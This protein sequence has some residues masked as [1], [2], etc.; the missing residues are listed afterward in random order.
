M[1][2]YCN[3]N[4]NNVPMKVNGKRFALVLRNAVQST[5][6]REWCAN[7]AQNRRVLMALDIKLGIKDIVGN[8]IQ[9]IEANIRRVSTYSARFDIRSVPGTVQLTVSECSCSS[10]ATAVTS[11]ASPNPL[12]ETVIRS[13]NF[14]N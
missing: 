6:R 8:T 11:L 5:R 14:A 9:Q 10:S 12:A 13:I 4:P 7:G 1:I 2:C 3:W